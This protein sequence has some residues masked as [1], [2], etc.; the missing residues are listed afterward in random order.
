MKPSG[1]MVEKSCA[2]IKLHSFTKLSW[3]WPLVLRAS[4][5]HLAVIG[6]FQ[7]VSEY[8]AL[9]GSQCLV[10]GMGNTND[11]L[12]PLDAA[13]THPCPGAG[14]RLSPSR[15]DE[16]CSIHLAMVWA[17]RGLCHRWMGWLKKCSAKKTSCRAD[18]FWCHR[19]TLVLWLSHVLSIHN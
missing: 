3:L 6:F 10:V 1:M 12:Q 14:N 15:Q 7:D 16:E 5:P 13:V 4:L 19:Q 2:L 9:R 18:D 11:M 17:I 8:R